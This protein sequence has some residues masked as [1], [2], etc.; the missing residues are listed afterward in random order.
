MVNNTDCVAVSCAVRPI[1]ARG[2]LI[3]DPVRLGSPDAADFNAVPTREPY[4]IHP[5]LLARRD[6]LAQ[7]GGYRYVH[8]AEDTDLYWRLQEFGGLHNLPDMLGDHRIHD[9]SI[10]GRSVING[11]ISATFSQLAALSARRRRA[12][13]PDLQFERDELRHYVAAGDLAAIIEHAALMITPPERARLEVTVAAKMLELAGY[14]PYELEVSD[15]RFIHSALR[16]HATLIR[17]ADRRAVD[18]M[19]A[20]TTA[21]LLR[22]GLLREAAALVAPRIWPAA[23]TRFALRLGPREALRMARRYAGRAHFSK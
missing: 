15:C 6:A 8:H 3:G 19:W 13:L 17:P 11:R 14:K 18:R 1:D 16:R 20:G 2:Q 9:G 10:T 7:A 22:K 21:R 23:A 4:L 5:F 12:D